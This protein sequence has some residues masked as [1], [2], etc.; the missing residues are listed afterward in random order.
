MMT[1]GDEAAVMAMMRQFYSS[2]AVLS[3]GSEEIFRNDIAACLE[4]GPWIEGYVFEEDGVL[5]GYA[6][7]AKTFNCEY[8]KPC[9]WIEDLFIL[10]AFRGRGIGG[11]FLDYIAAKYPES[12]LRLEAE[13]ENEGAVALYRRHGFDVL[14]YMQMKKNS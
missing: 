5:M 4:G 10:P 12:L 1:A 14:P 11:A 6:M 13:E 9:K 7:V 2:P 3:N 8:G